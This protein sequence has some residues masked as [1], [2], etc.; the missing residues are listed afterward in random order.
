MK[1]GEEAVLK[2]QIEDLQDHNHK[3]N[4]TNL[5]QYHRDLNLHD[6]KMKMN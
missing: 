4:R 2:H 6:Y 3:I 5:H 1:E